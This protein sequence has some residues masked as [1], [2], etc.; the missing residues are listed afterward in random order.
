MHLMRPVTA[1]PAATQFVRLRTN[2]SRAGPLACTNGLP[3]S[4]VVNLLGES[5]MS[6]DD[7][8]L[9]Q[10][11][12]DIFPLFGLYDAAEGLVLL[13]EPSHAFS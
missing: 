7:N 6:R 11:A 10:N 13:V 4:P 2:A 5:S 8:Q 9:K 12:T 3:V 1:L